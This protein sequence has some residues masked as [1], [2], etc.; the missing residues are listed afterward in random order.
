MLSSQSG[1]H[2]NTEM[3]S[4]S[5]RELG[6][7]TG[8]GGGEPLAG[9]W[10]GG[11]SGAR[12]PPGGPWEAGARP[13]DPGPV[14]AP[15]LPAPVTSSVRGQGR[16][17]WPAP[18][19]HRP[20]SSTTRTRDTEIIPAQRNQCWPGLETRHELL[21]GLVSSLTS[22]SPINLAQTRLTAFL[23]RW[24]TSLAPRLL[25]VGPV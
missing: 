8:G 21:P 4:D 3:S 2:T 17:L 16:G 14:Q 15:P 18:A 22:S 11:L 5:S 23:T 9:H 20:A 25:E 12:A 13:G 19:S 7:L 1:V 10:P 24:I 6:P